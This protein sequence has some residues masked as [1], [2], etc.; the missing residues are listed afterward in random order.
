MSLSMQNGSRS[1]LI[2]RYRPWSKAINKKPMPAELWDTAE[3][4]DSR[5]CDLGLRKGNRPHL[6]LD[7]SVQTGIGLKVQPISAHNNILRVKHVST[8]TGVEYG[9]A[10]ESLKDRPD[11]MVN[12]LAQIDL[13]LVDVEEHAGE[14]ISGN[15]MRK[16]EVGPLTQSDTPKCQPGSPLAAPYDL[17]P[18]AESDGGRW[19]GVDAGCT[20]TQP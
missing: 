9:Q 19:S 16:S 17:G 14:S 15:L 18:S 10:E 4:L 3:S 6:T 1:R 20:A 12:A 11:A 8:R 5:G 7:R 13:P 2:K